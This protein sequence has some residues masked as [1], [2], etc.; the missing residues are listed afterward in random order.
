V[1]CRWSKALAS[2][3]ETDGD[4]SYEQLDCLALDA[5]RE[6]LVATFT[7]KWE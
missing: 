1:E 4:V 5:E 7:V 2:L 3:L 6:W